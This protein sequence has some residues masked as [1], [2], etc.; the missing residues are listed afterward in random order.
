M[1][2]EKILIK[3]TSLI[4]QAQWL[5]LRE[6]AKKELLEDLEVDYNLMTHKFYVRLYFGERCRDT[7]NQYY[8]TEQEAFEAVESVLNR[9]N[10]NG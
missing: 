7:I 10:T 1:S 5:V 8:N 2:Q 9:R 6:R 4:T 3:E